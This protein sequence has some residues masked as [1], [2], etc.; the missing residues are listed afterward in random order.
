MLLKCLFNQ[1]RSLINKAES[2]GLLPE[3]EPNSLEKTADFTETPAFIAPVGLICSVLGRVL[4]G[5]P[6]SSDLSQSNLV[7]LGLT[8][9]GQQT[10]AYRFIWT[11]QLSRWR[12]QLNSFLSRGQRSQ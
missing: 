6:D 10:A 4:E 8:S 11:K 5:F 12:K 1:I 7:I 3:P 9:R 2:A